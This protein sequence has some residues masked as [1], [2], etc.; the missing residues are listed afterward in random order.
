LVCAFGLFRVVIRVSGCKFKADIA[1][2]AAY[3][4]P[5]HTDGQGK[6]EAGVRFGLPR[7][8]VVWFVDHWAESTYVSRE[9]IG[10]GDDRPS[11]F[12]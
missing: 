1:L 11:C 12:T 4:S 3:I 6:M 10:I 2:G 5:G 7:R 8:V 9:T